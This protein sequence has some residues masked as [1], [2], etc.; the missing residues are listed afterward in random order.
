MGENLKR[1][2]AQGFEVLGDRALRARMGPTLFDAMPEVLEVDYTFVSNTNTTPPSPGTDITMECV[3][4]QVRV[5]AGVAEIARGDYKDLLATLT[6]VGG[7][8]AAEITETS[9][10]GGGFRARLREER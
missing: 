3:E 2:I 7:I 9:S 10:Y 6:K 8:A 4:G 1:A 5:L